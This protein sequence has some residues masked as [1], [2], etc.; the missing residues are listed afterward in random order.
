MKHPPADRLIRGA[1]AMGLEV[2]PATAG[3]LLALWDRMC[4]EPQNLTAIDDV[5]EAV[6]RHLLDSL[7]GLGSPHIRGPVADI[8]SGG[9]FPG[10][11]LA[12]ARPDLEVTLVESERRK[13]RWLEDASAALPNV[14][15]VAD[16]TEHL[17]RRARA[18]FRTV[19]A[20]AVAPLPVT[21][22]L[23]APLLAPD[24]C[25]VVWS[26]ELP[27][28]ALAAAGVA[29]TALS[30]TPLEPLPVHPF[31]DARRV[32]RAYRRAGEVPGRYPRRPGRAAARP[33]A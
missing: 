8:G 21:L 23:A 5:Q 9:G 2:T 1:A 33:I 30:L 7:A 28:D 4:V 6:D 29:A 27:P 14:R 17:A 11:V 24:G 32:V 12:I 3:V 10:L 25:A 22:E 18:S 15:V 20:R 16:R 26:T 13:A 19:T 31:T